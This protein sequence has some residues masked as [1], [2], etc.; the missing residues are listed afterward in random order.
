MTKLPGR[1][2]TGNAIT[3]KEDVRLS[4][5]PVRRAPPLESSLQFGC[6][7]VWGMVTGAE[8]SVQ[9]TA[10]PSL[11]GSSSRSPFSWSIWGTWQYRILLQI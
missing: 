3:K 10:C 11:A 6:T 7:L 9:I 5:S 8:L 1:S 4:Q 2:P